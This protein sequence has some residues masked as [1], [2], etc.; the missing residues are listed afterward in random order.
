MNREQIIE[1]LKEELST[2]QLVNDDDPIEIIGLERAADRLEPIE[3]NMSRVIEYGK[4]D[5][6][7][8]MNHRYPISE[9]RIEDIMDNE[10]PPDEDDAMADVY[11][12]YWFKYGFR[13]ALKE[14]N[15][16]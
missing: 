9:E 11:N 2:I 7:K 12:R 3:P 6:D 5:I 13:A 1:I 4:A 10:I 15:K 14:L 8:W 16:E